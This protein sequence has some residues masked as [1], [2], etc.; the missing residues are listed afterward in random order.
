MADDLGRD[1]L[2]DLAFGLGIDRQCEIGM[3][4]DVDE[5][6]ADR[7][8]SG[9]DDPLCR[10]R[11]A[12]SDPGNPAV[13]NSE[14]GAFARPAA[15][16]VERAAADQDVPG[17]PTPSFVIPAKARIHGAASLRGFSYIFLSLQGGVIVM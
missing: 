9:V 7:Q 5:A 6:G 15:A 4:L 3:G 1:T 17:H 16:V 12:G 8:P 13:R 2:P 10:A 14:L 11:K